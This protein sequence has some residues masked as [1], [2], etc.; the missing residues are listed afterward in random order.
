MQTTEAQ[1]HGETAIPFNARIGETWTVQVKQTAQASSTLSITTA[2][3]TVISIPLSCSA[4]IEL[5]A[6]ADAHA[7]NLHV[8]INPS[9]GAPLTLVQSSGLTP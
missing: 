8:G 3:G 1:P 4:S 6:G 9:D 2:G 5:T 7:I